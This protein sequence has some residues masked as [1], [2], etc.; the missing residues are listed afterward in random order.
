MCVMALGLT[1][2]TAS[3]QPSKPFSVERV[4][5]PE[6]PTGPYKH[7]ACLTDLAGGDLYMVYYGGQ[8]EYARDTAVFG[9]RRPS[10]S[11][12]GCSCPR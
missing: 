3:R 8:G 11:A 9:S 6:V 10:G 12:T 2:V 4:F 1:A 5:G 7:P